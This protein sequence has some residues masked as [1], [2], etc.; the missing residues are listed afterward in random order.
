MTIAPRNLGG[1]VLAGGR[2]SRMAADKSVL[3][4]AGKPLI[5]HA[6]TKLRRI[7]AD[8]YILS[9]N[10]QHALYSPM[11]PDLHPGNGPLGGIEA[12][13]AHS[14][15]DWN[16]ILPVDMPFLPASVLENFAAAALDPASS[17]RIA[18]FEVDG[19]PQPAL[20]LLHKETHPYIAAEVERGQLKL[21]PAFEAA[22]VALAER[23]G[24][25]PGLRSGLI[26]QSFGLSAWTGEDRRHL[27]TEAQRA[28]AHL[29]FANLN[30]PEDFAE[31]QAHSDALDM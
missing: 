4:L 16:L 6:V 9:G 3:E 24:P 25:P 15:H 14:T 7:C 13:L 23:D 28:A 10:P 20:C 22:A 1:Y 30:T 26:S 11:V 17:C 21:L 27:T 29:W 31:A 2:S 8:V 19:R 18:V 5:E 12:A